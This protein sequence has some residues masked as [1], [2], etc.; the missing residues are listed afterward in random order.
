MEASFF[1][2][3]SPT[4]TNCQLFD[5]DPILTGDISLHSFDLHFSINKWCWTHFRVPFVHLYV[6]LVEMS[7]YDFTHFFL[8]GCVVFFPP[9]I[10]SYMSC[11]VYLEIKSLLV[12]FFS[13][14]FSHYICCLFILFM[15]SLFMQ[16]LW[17][18]IRSHLLIFIF[19]FISITLEDRSKKTLLW[20][21]SKGVV[22][23]FSFRTSVVSAFTFRSLMYFE[24]IFVYDV[25]KWFNLIL[26]HI[27]VQFSQGYLCKRLFFFS[28]IA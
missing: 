11:F 13:N 15:A 2:T 23:M 26:L 12:P 28:S 16:K 22:P 8:L 10:L 24:F 27:S 1:F 19:A 3:F 20:F 6:F 4:F 5:D 18:L 7:I 25:R 9:P 14:I 21:M 17:S